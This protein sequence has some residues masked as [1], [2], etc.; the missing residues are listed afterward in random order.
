MCALVPSHRTTRHCTAPDPAQSPTRCM[1]TK[2]FM[3]PHS[4]STASSG[5]CG[6]GGGG[7]GGAGERRVRDGIAG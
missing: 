6:A 3:A 2:K 4:S 5:C 7:S 1:K